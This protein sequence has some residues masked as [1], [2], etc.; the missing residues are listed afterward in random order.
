MDNLKMRRLNPLMRNRKLRMDKR[1]KV[2]HPMDNRKRPTRK[3]RRVGM[4]PKAGTLRLGQW[5]KRN[6]LRLLILLPLKKVEEFCLA[7]LPHKTITTT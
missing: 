6:S 1:L 4:L 3:G 5:G 2:R 7:V